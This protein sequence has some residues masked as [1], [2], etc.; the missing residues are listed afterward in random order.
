MFRDS[1]LPPPPNQWTISVNV[2]FMICSICISFYALGSRGSDKVY[3]RSH[4]YVQYFYLKRRALEDRWQ[5]VPALQTPA[6]NPQYVSVR[7]REDFPVCALSLRPIETSFCFA[8][9]FNQE[10]LMLPLV[11]IFLRLPQLLCIPFMPFLSRF[12]LPGIV[13]ICVHSWLITRDT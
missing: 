7:E 2:P 8:C 6:E 4:C 11:F 3:W 12:L 5:V 9:F 10:I 1:S 13:L